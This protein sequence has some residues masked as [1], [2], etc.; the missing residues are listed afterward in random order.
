MAPPGNVRR[1]LAARPCL[2]LPTAPDRR[3]L[4]SLAS[5]TSDFSANFRPET[6]CNQNIMSCMTAIDFAPL[7]L[8][9]APFVLVPGF[10]AYRPQKNY[11]S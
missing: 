6:D 10:D 5:P 1:A 11:R 3:K 9:D 4:C 8:D 7:A 2:P